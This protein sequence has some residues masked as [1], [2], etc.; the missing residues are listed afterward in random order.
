MAQA[1]RENGQARSSL[2]YLD[3]LDLDAIKEKRT[4]RSHCLVMN[5]NSGHKKKVK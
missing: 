1:S 3:F 2:C 5:I 4:A